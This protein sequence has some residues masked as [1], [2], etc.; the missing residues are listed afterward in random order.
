MIRTK[1]KAVDS[2]SFILLMNPQ[3]FLTNSYYGCKHPS[4]IWFLKPYYDV[5]KCQKPAG[6]KKHSSL[7]LCV[8]IENDNDASGGRQ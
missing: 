3:E 1:F 2:F 4:I 7:M 8:I 6:D 5:H